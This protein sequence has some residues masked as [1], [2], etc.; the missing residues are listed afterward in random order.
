MWKRGSAV[1]TARDIKIVLEP[2]I[3]LVNGFN[4]QI[5]KIRPQ[6]AGDY[7]CQISTMP[8]MEQTHTLEVL[9]KYKIAA[10]LYISIISSQVNNK[11]RRVLVVHLLYKCQATHLCQSV[12][13]LA[14]KKIVEESIKG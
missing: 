1:L 10:E 9:G 12:K 7:I 4:L 6:D 3:Q 5:K 11:F 14:K 13:Y 8:P 2:R